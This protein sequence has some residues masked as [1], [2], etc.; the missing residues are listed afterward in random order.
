MSPMIR[1]PHACLAHGAIIRGT[2][3]ALGLT[4]EQLAYMIGVSPPTLLRLECGYSPIRKRL[5]AAAY[6]VLEML[7]VQVAASTPDDAPPEIAGVVDMRMVV[8]VEELRKQG[9][10]LDA[11][12]KALLGEDFIPPLDKKPL[13]K[14]TPRDPIPTTPRS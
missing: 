7:G 2:R 9:A 13:I 4:Q 6:E 5:V 11:I 3:A 1:S 14:E 8:N 10:E 12:T